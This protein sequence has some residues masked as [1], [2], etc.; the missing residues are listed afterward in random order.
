M[1][2][3]V[4][5][6]AIIGAIFAPSADNKLPKIKVLVVDKDKNIA[7]KFLLG[8]FDLPELKDMFQV[9]MVDETEGKK[10][11][12]AGKASAMVVIPEK[13]SDRFIKAEKS[14]IM[15][16]KNPSEQFLPNVVEEFMITYAVVMSGF[17]QVFEPELKTI[18]NFLRQ[19]TPLEQVSI[20][21]ITPFLEQG[22]NKIAALKNYLS[23]LLI[24]LKAETTGEKKQGCSI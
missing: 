12:A 8:A 9:T 19:D 3:P 13:F 6:T 21:S 1:A 7:A 22:K 24:Q 15:V 23:P 5:M 10:L 20:A 11:M 4:L 17:I 2:I 14:E 18:D 16:I